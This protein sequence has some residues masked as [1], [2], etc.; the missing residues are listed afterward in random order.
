MV[1]SLSLGPPISFGV[2]TGSRVCPFF[3]PYFLLLSLRDGYPTRSY[4]FHRH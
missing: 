3:G 4:S 1:F 2:G